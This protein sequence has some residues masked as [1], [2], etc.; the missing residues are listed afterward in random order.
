MFEKFFRARE[1]EVRVAEFFESGKRTKECKT[2]IFEWNWGIYR[3]RGAEAGYVKAGRSSIA[4][5]V[6][7]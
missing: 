2:L 7:W 4:E 6:G 5:D 3:G 1:V